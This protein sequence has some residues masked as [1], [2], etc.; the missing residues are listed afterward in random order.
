MP[1]VPKSLVLACADDEGVDTETQ[2]KELLVGYWNAAVRTLEAS[3]Y[4]ELHTI[5]ERLRAR[6]QSI[7]SKLLPIELQQEAIHRILDAVSTESERHRDDSVCE[8][9]ASENPDPDQW[10]L[11]HDEGGAA[12]LID[13]RDPDELWKTVSDS[14]RYWRKAYPTETWMDVYRRLVSRL[15]SLDEE[16]DSWRVEQQICSFRSDVIDR[17][18]WE[19]ELAGFAPRYSAE[20]INLSDE[21]LKIDN[22]ALILFALTVYRHHEVV[23]TSQDRLFGQVAETANSYVEEGQRY[24]EELKPTSTRDGKWK[25]FNV[26]DR[27]DALGIYVSKHDG[28]QGAPPDSAAMLE[29]MIRK[30]EERENEA[31]CVFDDTSYLESI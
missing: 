6:K 24:S 27:I 5:Y 13:D 7:D 3:G 12:F 4:L 1:R 28:G 19:Y 22:A 16:A 30:L 29:A 15:Q 2:Q 18:L 21:P 14:L 8:S 9:I 31:R 23:R 11:W 26:R 10:W 17:V 20:D 25:S